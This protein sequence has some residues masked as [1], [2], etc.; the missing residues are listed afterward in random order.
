MRLSSNF[1]A[2]CA[3]ISLMLAQRF[4]PSPE[5]QHK[6]TWGSLKE[7]KAASVLVNSRE[8]RQFSFLNPGQE[9]G[10]GRRRM[11]ADRR[12]ALERE[13]RST[14]IFQTLLLR[15]WMLLSKNRAPSWLRSSF[16]GKMWPAKHQHHFSFVTQLSLIL[17]RLDE[18]SPAVA[19]ARV[20][21]ICLF[22]KKLI[23]NSLHEGKKWT[24]F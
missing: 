2:R 14:R 8:E 16:C 24:S 20:L 1:H 10:W 18:K 13:A 11:A 6:S 21:F 17:T 7:C 3:E 12:S 19:K 23:F 4:L 9:V 5:K 22:F 15:L